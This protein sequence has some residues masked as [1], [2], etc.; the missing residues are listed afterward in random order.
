MLLFVSAAVGV[1]FVA[2]QPVVFNESDGMVDIMLNKNASTAQNIL[3]NILLPE[4]NHDSCWCDNGHPYLK[5]RLLS[6]RMCVSF[7]VPITIVLCV[8]LLLT[9]LLYQWI[10]DS[11]ISV[12]NPVTLPKGLPG[13]VPVSLMITDDTRGGEADEMI[14]LSL[15]LVSPMEFSHLIDLDVAGDGVSDQLIIIVKDNDRKSIR[16]TVC[17]VV[18]S[19][20]GLP[21]MLHTVF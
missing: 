6:I 4:G 18:I 8:Y 16:V 15:E 10:S 5:L 9:I 12:S 14:M 3:V 20:P 19:R 11:P 13:N 2:S 1:G 17:G 21:S 7:S